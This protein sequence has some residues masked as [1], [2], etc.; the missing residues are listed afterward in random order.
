MLY[1]TMFR[2]EYHVLQVGSMTNLNHENGL[3]VWLV[4][5]PTIRCSP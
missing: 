3:I 2:E 4:L 5:L 1:D